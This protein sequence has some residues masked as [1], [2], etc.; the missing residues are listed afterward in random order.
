MLGLLYEVIPP[1][2]SS[3]TVF[4]QN[5]KDQSN[6]Q[7]HANGL[8]VSLTLF[9]PKKILIKQ[10]AAFPFFP[11]SIFIVKNWDKFDL[12]SACSFNFAFVLSSILSIT[13][14]IFVIQSRI[15]LVAGN[16]SFIS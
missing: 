14:K 8:I 9:S 5:F 1:T 7:Q 13:F 4:S 3:L 15:L 10:T 16:Y 12:Y 6:E 11:F 2:Q